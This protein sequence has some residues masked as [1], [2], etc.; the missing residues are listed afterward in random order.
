[1][2]SVCKLPNLSFQKLCELERLKNIY[3][4]FFDGYYTLYTISKILE[5]DIETAKNFVVDN[6]FIKNERGN[7][8]YIK[9]E[10]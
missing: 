2:N 7:Y 6:N 10:K 9:N 4:D 8:K 1:M 3:I 5:V